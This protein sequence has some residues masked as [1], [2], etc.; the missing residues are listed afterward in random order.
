MIAGWQ[1]SPDPARRRLLG[2]L[3]LSAL[4]HALLVGLP[5]LLSDAGSGAAPA[6]PARE[7]QVQIVARRL[8]S[9]PEA[10]PQSLLKDTL[11]EHAASAAPAARSPPRRESSGPAHVAP[12]VAPG[13]ELAAQ[14]KLHAHLF[15]PPEAVAGGLEGEARL[16]LTLDD[17]GRILEAE[18]ARSSGHALLDRAALEAARAA[19]RLPGVGARELILPVVFRLE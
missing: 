2:C 10:A 18:I 1:P 16:L 7:L 11:A 12:R 5:P 17:Q 4:G 19:Q 13:G 14:R 9:T 8:P 6:L 3:A 15:Y